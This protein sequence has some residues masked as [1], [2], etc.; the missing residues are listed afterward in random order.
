MPQ[1]QQQQQ[2]QQQRIQIYDPAMALI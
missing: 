1:Q 2:Q